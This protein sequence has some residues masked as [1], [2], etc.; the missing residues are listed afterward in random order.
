MYKLPY[1]YLFL[2]ISRQE[3]RIV[4]WS[5]SGVDEYWVSDIQHGRPLCGT[6]LE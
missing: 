2:S 6:Q 4:E 1:F 3:V 5:G